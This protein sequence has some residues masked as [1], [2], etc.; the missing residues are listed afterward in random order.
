MYVAIIASDWCPVTARPLPD[1]AWFDSWELPQDRPDPLDPSLAD[2]NQA[3]N[4]QPLPNKCQVVESNCK[5]F[6]GPESPAK[7]GSSNA[8]FRSPTKPVW[9]TRICLRSLGRIG[10]AWRGRTRSDGKSPEGYPEPGT[11]ALGSEIPA[12]GER[13]QSPRRD[14]E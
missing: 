3:V 4:Q 11:S 1:N 6:G 7:A 8:L 9:W 5:R 13:L 10:L 12:P 2:V 14:A